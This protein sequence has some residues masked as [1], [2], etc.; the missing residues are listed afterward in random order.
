MERTV[1]VKENQNIMI[2]IETMGQGS[3]AAVVAIGAVS[4]D[5]DGIVDRFY[6]KIDL[7]EAAKYG[8]IDPDTI[9]WWLKQ[10]D[11]A[12]SELDP[13][14]TKDINTVMYMLESYINFYGNNT[15]IWGNGSDFDNVILSNLFRKLAIVPPWQFWNNRCYRTIKNIFSDVKM[16]RTGTHH[17][18][19]DDAISQAEHL[20]S[21]CK[22][23]NIAM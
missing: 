7:R 15:K 9:L 19:L 23:H 12:R 22:K 18:A 10:S 17:N 21:I 13:K 16:E 20:I 2:D 3:N 4:F 11:E 8:D 1:K 5:N 6:E 14:E